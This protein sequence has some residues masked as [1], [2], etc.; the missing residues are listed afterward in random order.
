MGC[1]NSIPF[2]EKMTEDERYKY[3]QYISMFGGCYV[4][5]VKTV[6]VNG[7]LDSAS[8]TCCEYIGKNNTFESKKWKLNFISY[9]KAKLCYQYYHGQITDAEFRNSLKYRDGDLHVE[10]CALIYNLIENIIQ[11]KNLNLN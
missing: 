9:E 4:F 5:P 2:E 6:H 1:N 7:M 3:G 8:H 11:R 10:G